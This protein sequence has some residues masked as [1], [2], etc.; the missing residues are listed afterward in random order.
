MNDSKLIAK[1]LATSFK[2]KINENN[3][4]ELTNLFEDWIFY[5]R[6]YGVKWNKLFL[7]ELNNIISEELFFNILDN[8]DLKY[9]LT[10]SNIKDIETI[11]NSKQQKILF[12]NYDTDIDSISYL[13]LYKTY[14]LKKHMYS[15]VYHYSKIFNKKHKTIKELFKNISKN[16]I[17]GDLFI[18]DDQ[19][20]QYSF[21][22]PKNRS[23]VFLFLNKGDIYSIDV[24]ISQRYDSK[25]IVPHFIIIQS[26]YDKD[27]NIFKENIINKNKLEY[28]EII[29]SLNSNGYN[30][31]KNIVKE[32]CNY[33]LCHESNIEYSFINKNIF[34]NFNLISNMKTTNSDCKINF[35]TYKIIFSNFSYSHPDIDFKYIDIQYSISFLINKYINNEL[36]YY[37]KLLTRKDFEIIT[38]AL[39]NIFAHIKNLIP[40]SS[41]YNDFN[42]ACLFIGIERQDDID[43][44]YKHLTLKDQYK[45]INKLNLK[46]FNRIRLQLL[47]HIIEEISKEA[48]TKNKNK[49]ETQQELLNYLDITEKEVKKVLKSL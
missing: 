4:Y 12:F 41:S 44:L 13:R 5:Y 16:S 9:D 47:K 11:I 33:I 24:S 30:D 22:I 49:K 8:F 10:N 46:T 17:S 32:K 15:S 27:I 18:Y 48:K 19:N 3:N 35:N 29:E 45:K 7:N 34:N 36:E 31:I 38:E 6:Y 43:L 25:I 21:S 40:K 39:E 14:L 37:K 2:D 28:N 26:S 1:Q 42:Q 20:D 23:S